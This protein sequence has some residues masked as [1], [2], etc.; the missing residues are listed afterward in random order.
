[1]GK[2][3]EIDREIFRLSVPT[4]A[5]NVTIP[6]LGICDTAISGHLGSENFL[7]AIAVGSVMLNVVFWIFGFLRGGTT[8]LTANAL[9]AKNNDEISKV[10]YRALAIALLAGILLICLQKPIFSGLWR[11]AGGSDA[12]K[13]DVSDYFTIRI[14]GSPALL[15]IIAMS[16]WFVGMQSTFYPMLIAIATN[17]INIA[18][19]YLLAFP[20]GY[21]FKGV[22]IG[23][24]IANWLGVLIAVGCM[25]WFLKG[26][27][28]K[29]SFSNF[30][31]GDWWKYFSV[32]ANLFLRSLFIICVTMGITAAGAR[33]STLTLAINVIVMQF[34]QF[35]S[36]FIDGFAYSGEAMIGLRSGERNLEMMSRCAK[37]LL[38][39]T[40]AT[41][42]LFSVG[43]FFSL[44]T[45]ASLLTDSET[46]VEG[47]AGLTLW[48]ALIPI[49][50][51][52]AFI[53]DGF[54]IGVTDTYKMMI[55]SLAGAV[56][57]FV[58]IYFGNAA[59]SFQLDMEKNQVI[60]SAFLC[61]LGV[62]GLYL[63]LMWPKTVASKFSLP[64]PAS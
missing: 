39:W 44:E 10:L 26:K 35:F 3:R 45:V 27:F 62:R 13:A 21:G 64:T 15:A 2:F 41:G 31:K 48:I 28:L 29:C 1:M 6:L 63:F 5:S 20:L 34:F 32:N 36:F 8:G 22:A 33:I 47:V 58:F 30:I 51:C 43:Y 25:L 37:R 40:F 46:V 14:W 53:F 12:I 18:A 55:S 56:I 42:I 60:W 19:S 54:Y 24:C 16:G 11:V 50:S 49:V 52:W 38:Q 7:A 57:F 9:G 59:F 61:Y 4:I 23:T 17:I